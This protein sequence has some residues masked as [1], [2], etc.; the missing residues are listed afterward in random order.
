MSDQFIGIKWQMTR[1]TNIG[2]SGRPF[3][4]TISFIGGIDVNNTNWL[5]IIIIATNISKNL[6]Q[7]QNNQKKAS[8]SYH[9]A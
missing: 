9:K 6:I 8:F 5:L 7:Q 4:M 3:W 1:A 2:S